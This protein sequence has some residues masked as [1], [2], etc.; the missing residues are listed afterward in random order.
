MGIQ[1]LV[2]GKRQARVT[3]MNKYFFTLLLILF[4]PYACAE[5]SENPMLKEVESAIVRQTNE[6]RKRESLPKITPVDELTKAAADFAK[7]MAETGKYGHQADGRT[8]G[9]RAK[10][11]GFELCIVRENIAYRTNTGEVTADSLIDVFMKGWIDSPPHRENML[12]PHITQTG[13]AVA[14]TDDNTYFAVQLF[15]RPRSEAIKLSVTNESDDTRTLVMEADESSDEIQMPA[16]SMVTITRCLPT[17]LR[18]ADQQESITLSE[19]AKLII[20]NAGIKKKDSDGSQHSP[21]S[22]TDRIAHPP[23]LRPAGD[24]SQSGESGP[25][26]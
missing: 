19:S 22:D 24:V 10:E 11:A 3:Q 8:P 17:T 5:T 1:V 15:G 6:L 16:R 26:D 9:A 7:F 12:A 13:V 23:G 18:L 4:A 21:A 20:T 2:L 25:E 14:T